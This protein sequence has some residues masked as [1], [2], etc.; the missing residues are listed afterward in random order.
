MLK[1]VSCLKCHFLLVIWAG[2]QRNIV[3]FP[4][5]VRGICGCSSGAKWP[6]L[7]ADHS[8]IS[9]ADVKKERSCAYTPTVCCHGEQRGDLNFT[10]GTTECHEI[11]NEREPF[12]V[13]L[14]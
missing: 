12:L 6:G 9:C 5:G 4:A 1:N 8:P 11:R 3:H 14:L 7:E 2:K 13:M 10:W